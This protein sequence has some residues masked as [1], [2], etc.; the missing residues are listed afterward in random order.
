MK[1]NRGNRG[2][3]FQNKFDDGGVTYKSK[4]QNRQLAFKSE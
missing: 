1:I 2:I 3:E 4:V